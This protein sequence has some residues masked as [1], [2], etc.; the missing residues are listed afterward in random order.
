M[1]DSFNFTELRENEHFD[2]LSISSAAPFPQ[3]AEFKAWQQ[4]LGREVKRFLI[5]F[6]D[7]I[8]G[9]FQTIQYELPFGKSFVYAPYGPFIKG[10][11]PETLPQLLLELKNFL[12]K[13]CGARNIVFI[14]L[15]F[16]LNTGNNSE[17]TGALSRYFKRAPKSTFHSAYLQ[18]RTEWFLDITNA[19]D[20]LLKRM[21]EKT[22]YLINLSARKGIRTE[23]I[24][25]DFKSYFENFYSLLKETADRNGFFLHPK[26]YYENIF[27]EIEENQKKGISDAFLSVARYE[28]KI[29]VMN[30]VIKYGDTAHFIFGGSSNEHRNIS[31]SHAA[32]WAGILH[33]KKIGAKNYNF[34][35]ISEVANESGTKQDHLSSLTSFKKK[36]GGRAVLHKHCYDLVIKPFWY[37]LYISRKIVKNFLTHM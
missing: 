12:L 10:I 25:K 4:S 26:K 28:N 30:L 8:L 15:D 14:R 34:G 16:S 31:P 33:A 21:H 11:Y 5:K 18:P 1:N 24:E 35:G 27:D 6:G 36:F 2:P 9:F 23:I 29:L 19:E 20:A 37:H 17:T 7:E 22:R 3:S 32:H 13:T